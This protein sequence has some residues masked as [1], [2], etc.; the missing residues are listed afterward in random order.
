MSFE[1]MSPS[2]GRMRGPAL[3]R[4]PRRL[5]S[6]AT[7]VAMLSTVFLW[8]YFSFLE[9]VRPY[10]FGIKEV[11]IGLNKGIQKDPYGPGLWLV[12]PFGM[13][14]M[15]RLPRHV[16]VLELTGI[17][18]PESHSAVLEGPSVF[19]DQQAKIQ[20]S[21]GFFVDVDAS[22][23]YRITD[24]YKVITT[25]GPSE[26][27]MQMGVRPRAQP[28]LKQT[29]GQ[30]TTEEFYN[31]EL[32]VARA[33]EA[34]VLLNRELEP[35]GIRIEQVLV[36]YFKY[37]DSIQQNIEAKKLQDQLFYTNQ[38]KA[39]AAKQQQELDRVMAEGEQSVQ[40]ALQEG[41]A[42]RTRIQA[43]SDLYSRTKK[44]EA[45]LLIKLAEAQR[46]ELRNT[47]M[48][49]GGSDRMVALRMAEVL[50]GLD[51]IVLPAGSPESFNP[52]DLDQVLNTFG[53]DLGA[54]AP[55]Q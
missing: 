1:K 9:Y 19:R 3:P 34:K 11:K 53:L 33:E 6:L 41:S 18:G 25:L 15:H 7:I 45:D 50:Q 21:D 55:A 48:Q 39:L 22:V 20:T 52:L 13:Q 38:S 46:T 16:Q 28:A 32:R 27:H 23:L 29:L 30:L 17:G 35:L 5:A 54:P 37:I 49:Q 8:A 40:L 36:R 42:Y 26:A 44:A 14:I 31:S 10:E 43:E 4:F 24:P 2:P 12:M 51:T 47:A